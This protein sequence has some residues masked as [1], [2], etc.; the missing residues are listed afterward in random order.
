MNNLSVIRAPYIQNLICNSMKIDIPIPCPSCGG[1]M[2]STGYQPTLRILKERSWQ[3]CK[4]CH[5][6]RSTENIKKS[7]C[8]A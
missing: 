4:E 2:Y 3:V 7:I 1:K 5:F 8:C 6:Q